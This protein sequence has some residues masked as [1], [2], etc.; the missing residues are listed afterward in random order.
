MEN[1]ITRLRREDNYVTNP[2]IPVPD[3]RRNPPQENI[4]RFE[5]TDNPQRPS[6]PRQPTSNAVVLDDVYDE[7]VIE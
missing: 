5:N 7:Q 4:V 3:K 6:V 2:R 1:E